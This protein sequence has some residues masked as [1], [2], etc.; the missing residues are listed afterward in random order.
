MNSSLMNNL[1]TLLQDCTEDLHCRP[2]VQTR[3]LIPQL[4]LVPENNP[5]ILILVSLRQV[6]SPPCQAHP[7][8]NNA[9][10]TTTVR[11]SPIPF[12]VLRVYE[13]QQCAPCLVLGHMVL[14][15]GSRV[16]GTPIHEL[17]VLHVVN[18]GYNPYLS[19]II[20]GE[21]GYY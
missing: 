18:R 10:L 11:L 20:G 14:E 2:L 6:T 21:G 16:S 3:P 4:L 8:A 19:G 17:R 5:R 7:E 13:I 12:P 15:V 1:L 9:E